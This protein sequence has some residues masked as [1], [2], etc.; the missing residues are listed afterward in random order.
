M[1]QE[2]RLVVG[3]MKFGCGMGVVMRLTSFSRLIGV[4]QCQI[5]GAS[6]F[7][8]DVG[9]KKKADELFLLLPCLT[10]KHSQLHPMLP[11]KSVTRAKFFCN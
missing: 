2:R 7:L 6:S 4:V 5:D 9:R 11:Y 8:K 1:G 10:K 3:G